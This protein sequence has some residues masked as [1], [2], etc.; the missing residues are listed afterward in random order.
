[1]PTRVPESTRDPETMTADERRAE[2]AATLACGLLRAVRE[3]RARISQSAQIP[4]RGGAACLDS[5]AE[6]RLSV[7]PRP[8]G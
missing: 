5:P 3:T 1:M 8:H 4:A 6:V 7:A 2:V